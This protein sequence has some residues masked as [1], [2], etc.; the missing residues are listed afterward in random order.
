MSH[1]LPALKHWLALSQLNISGNKLLQF[2]HQHADIKR[3]FGMSDTQ[4][5][6]YGFRAG[7]ANKLDATD[8]QK[9]EQDLQW[10]D[11]DNKHLIPVGS[12]D[13]PTLLKQTQGAPA[14]LFCYG[15][16][17]VL[18]QH[19]IAIV[20]SRN[21]SPQGKNN[22]EQFALSLAQAGA[23]ITS[24]LALGIDGYAHQA[25]VNANLATIAVTGTGLDRVY[26]ARHKE[27]AEQIIQQGALV[28]DFAL[29]TGVRASNFPSRN[30]I[31]TG[32]SLGT[33][34]VEAAIKSG[35][36]ISARLAGEQGREVFAIPGSIHNPLAKGCH[37]LIK[38]GAKLVETAEEIIEELQALALWQLESQET[39][40]AQ[41]SFELDKD[42]QQL[43]QQIDYDTTSI[44]QILDR[45]GLE[46]GV[47]SHMLLLLELNNHIANV[48]GGYQRK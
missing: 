10:F 32:M 2:L 24:G 35:S 15:N 37:Q 31:I 47:V 40:S 42:Y 34:V 17:S 8:W 44:E 4:L 6:S 39:S 19:Q 11:Q 33:L 38:Q 1:S 9:V 48:A 46:I 28:S 5:Q 3:L 7:L 16:K 30:R 23:V 45:S 21:P 36:L 18:N 29:G 26:P 27:L 22:A 20:G 13:Y 12:N 14:L 43:L 41:A 25:V